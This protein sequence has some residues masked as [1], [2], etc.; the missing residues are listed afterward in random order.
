M[1]TWDSTHHPRYECSGIQD[2]LSIAEADKPKQ[3]K[4]E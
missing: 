2:D 3:N 1:L 4:Q